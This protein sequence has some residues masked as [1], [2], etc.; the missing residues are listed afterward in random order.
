MQRALRGD[1]SM[2]E[3]VG[4]DGV[5]RLYVSAP[6]T[7]GVETGLYVGMGIERSVALGALANER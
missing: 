5:S 2:E 6:V 1:T 4:V 3:E 7:A